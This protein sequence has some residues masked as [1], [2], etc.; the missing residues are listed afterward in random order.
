[1]SSSDQYY[2][3]DINHINK[4]HVLHCRTVR[5]EDKRCENNDQFHIDW[6]IMVFIVNVGPFAAPVFS[7][8]MKQSTNDDHNDTKKATR[9]IVINN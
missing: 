2:L 5:E 7:K 4:I 3:Q 6:T 9:T 8:F 1:M